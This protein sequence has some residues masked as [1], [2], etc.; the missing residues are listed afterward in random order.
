MHLFAFSI[1]LIIVIGFVSNQNATSL[2]DVQDRFEELLCPMPAGSGLWNNTGT[3]TY[4]GGTYN[5]PNVSN[6]TLTLT[7]TPIHTLDGVDY[8]FGQPTVAVGVFFFAVD[9]I[10]EGLH[11]V[12][13]FFAIIGI[14]LTPI[15]FEILGFDLNDVGTLGTMAI[16]SMYL[17][18]YTWIGIGIYKVVNPFGGS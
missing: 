5:Y 1:V 6:Q 16:I 8:A 18:C 17:F 14:Y 7:C 3:I 4:S 11:K 2:S 15:N 13:S 12:G 9:Y 10:S